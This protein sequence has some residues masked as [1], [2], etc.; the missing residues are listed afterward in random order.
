MRI[1]WIT[2]LK[3]VVEGGRRGPA[4]RVPE[5][6]GI[7]EKLMDLAVRGTQPFVVGVDGELAAQQL[8]DHPDDLGDRHVA[9]GRDVVRAADDSVLLG[10]GPEAGD[11]VVDEHEVAGWSRG[12]EMDVRPGQGLRDHGRDDGAEGLAWPVGVERTRHYDG[13]VEGQ[14]EGLGQLV[15]ADLARRVGALGVERVALVDRRV[16]RGAVDLA[17]AHLDH[18]L[19]VRVADG[20]EH[21]ERRLPHWS[22]RPRAARGSCTGPRSRRQG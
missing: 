6:R 1:Q 10:E 19:D 3:A 17:R 11:G 9:P 15:G 12:A 20:A 2:A 16:L 21:V 14:V 22:S 18:P 7:A 5:L 4:G 13:Q 8:S